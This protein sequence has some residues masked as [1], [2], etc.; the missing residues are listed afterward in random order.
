[1]LLR[2][3]Q[4]LESL[5]HVNAVVFDK[6][7]TLTSDRMELQHMFTPLHEQGS[8]AIDTPASQ[9][10]L[11]LTAALAEH[12]WHPFARAVLQINNPFPV[13]PVFQRVQEHV[14]QGVS[15]TWMDGSDR[16][17]LR[18]GSLA[19]CQ[20]GA[21]V[22]ELPVSAQSA[23]VHVF[24]QNGWLVSYAF[25]EVLRPDALQT[26]NA[27]RLQGMSI[28]LMSGDKPAAVHAVAQRLQL[29]PMHVYAA[30]QPD[31]KLSYLK[32]LQA[33]GKRVAM[34]GDGFNDMPVMA[35]A[36]VSFAFGQAVPLAQAHSDVVVMGQQLMAVAN[37]MAL[38]GK[39]M[40]VVRHNLI[41]A[42]A[43]NAVCVPLAVMGYLPAWLAGL[44][45]ALS[46]VVVVLYSLQLA[47]NPKKPAAAF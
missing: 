9:R 29:D 40:R 23:Q 21:S 33:A 19:F 46:S 28:Y 13:Q 6:T 15:A 42:A 4:S 14:G 32:D 41:W 45:M 24:D 31:D 30:C 38:A 12:S 47:V 18:M 5:A 17:E 39:S 37:T 44:G 2:D 7:G 11:S 8:P 34:V 35:G 3:V 1:V 27:L 36:H 26:M 22:S 10:L 43:Y 20:A 16:R 25:R